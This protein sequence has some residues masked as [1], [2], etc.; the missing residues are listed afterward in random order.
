MS[1]LKAASYVDEVANMH[2][3]HGETQWIQLSFRK[4][5]GI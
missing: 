5:E 4:K 2:Y 1:N 3:K